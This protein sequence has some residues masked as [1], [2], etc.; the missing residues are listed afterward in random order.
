MKSPRRRAVAVV[1]AILLA[2]LLA[3]LWRLGASR[4]KSAPVASYAATSPFVKQGK[5]PPAR[6][7]KRRSGYSIT[8]RAEGEKPDAESPPHPLDAE[9]ATRAARWKPWRT[10]VV[11]LNFG[12]IPLPDALAD[13]EKRYGLK[14]LIA[15]GRD[16]SEKTITFRVMSLAADQAVDLIFKM[17]DLKWTLAADGT[18]VILPVDGDGEAWGVKDSDELTLLEAM[19]QIRTQEKRAADHDNVDDSYWGSIKGRVVAAEV[20]EAELDDSFDLLHQSVQLNFVLSANARRANTENPIVP[21][22]AAGRPLAETLDAWCAATGFSW[23]VK[24][25]LIYFGTEAEIAAEKDSDSRRRAERKAFASELAALLARKVR[26]GGD[27]LA[28]RQ[29]AGMLGEALGVPVRLDPVTWHRAARITLEESE[30]PAEDVVRI[31]QAAAPVVV[32]FR[33]GILW[34]LAPAPPPKNQ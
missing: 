26:I 16:L 14:F 6:D 25:S 11:D 22:L 33:A 24:N 17:A 21:A 20:P 3:G 10:T 12:D 23:K 1:A 2:A 28:I 34:F 19:E 31:I 29:I 9:I 30:R 13:M 5:K 8:P 18:L 4:S 7:F 15:G 27:N 32:S